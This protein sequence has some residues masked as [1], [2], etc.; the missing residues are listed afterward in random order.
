M[1]TCEVYEASLVAQTAACQT[2]ERVAA[3]LFEDYICLMDNPCRRYSA[4]ADSS[5]DEIIWS[6]FYRVYL[7]S[8]TAFQKE[9]LKECPLK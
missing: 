3:A 1:L 7:V 9:C 5:K 2:M 4:L 8:W 6:R